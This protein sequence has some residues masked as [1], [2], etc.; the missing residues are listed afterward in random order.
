MRMP[1]ANLFFVPQTPE[2]EA[3]WSFSHLANH[4]DFIRTV[5]QK[6]GIVL[7]E[8]AIDPFGDDVAD[9]HQTLH[10]DLDSLI[11]VQ[12]FD[13]SEVNWKDPQQRAAWIFLNA[14]LHQQEGAIL[15]VG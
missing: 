12:G 11:G 14:T 6:F 10:N 8:Y 15:G 5:Q 9:L 1:I 13:L 7:P 3:A 2:Q 4:R